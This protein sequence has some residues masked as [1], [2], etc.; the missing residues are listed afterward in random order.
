LSLSDDIDRIDRE[1]FGSSTNQKIVEGKQMIINY[2][3]DLVSCN[4]SVQGSVNDDTSSVSEHQVSA[5]LPNLNIQEQRSNRLLAQP[6]KLVRFDDCRDHSKHVEAFCWTCMM[7]IC[8]D[9]ILGIAS[10][11]SANG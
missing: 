5:A 10:R 4:E 9:C 1:S 3:M 11:S 2:G 7:P 6:I 8:I